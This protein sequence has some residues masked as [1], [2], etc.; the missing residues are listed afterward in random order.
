MALGYTYSIQTLWVMSHRV[1]ALK[2]CHASVCCSSF[3][4]E[5]Q[6]SCW[7]WRSKLNS[8]LGCII[9]FNISEWWRPGFKCLWYHYTWE[10]P[11]RFSPRVLWMLR[12]DY[13]IS[14]LVHHTMFLAKKLHN[15]VWLGEGGREGKTRIPG[16]LLYLVLVKSVYLMLVSN[17]YSCFYNNYR[18]YCTVQG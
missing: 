6:L 11:T 4:V 13:L 2:V 17:I 7:P 12:G 3:L 1:W 5:I 9:F 16:C 18:N 10:M 15:R 8:P 14:I